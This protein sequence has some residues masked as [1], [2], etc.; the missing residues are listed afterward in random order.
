LRKK[1]KPSGRHFDRALP[2]DLFA[3]L[4]HFLQDRIHQ[5]LATK[6]AGAFHAIFL[7]HLDQLGRS[8]FLQFFQMHI[9]V[10]L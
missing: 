8:L 3:I 4:G 1:P 7:S 9:K 5:I 2:N 6:R 10:F